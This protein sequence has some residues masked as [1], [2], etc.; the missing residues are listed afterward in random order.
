MTKY[1]HVPLR[2]ILK[3]ISRPVT[4]L[5]GRTYRL[6][7]AQW[8]AKGLFER[9]RKDGTEIRAN[10]LFEVK[11]GDFIY[12]RLF[13]W[14]GSFAIASKSDEGG[15]VSNEFPCFLVG[16]PA[17]PSWL[18]WYFTQESVWY[19]ALTR[20]SGGTPTSRNRLK[21]QD[22][23]A[24]TIPLPSPED[25]T[26]MIARLDAVE[27]LLSQVDAVRQQGGDLMKSVLAKSFGLA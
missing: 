17:D 14:K 16:P 15:V 4:I 13:A 21:E 12:N 23:L 10:T 20:S 25:Q 22:F 8:Y 9:D 24:M 1:P 19:D 2:E 6:L 5:P 7:G 11:A 26:R 18:R 3:S 27:R